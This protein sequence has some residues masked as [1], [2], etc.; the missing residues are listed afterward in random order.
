MKLMNLKEHPELKERFDGIL[1]EERGIAGMLQLIT[2][3]QANCLEQR[4]TLWEDIFKAAGVEMDEW[5]ATFRIKEATVTFWK[6]TRRKGEVK[7]T[8][9]RHDK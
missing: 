9:P 7:S 3:M 1:K 5:D 2:G 6:K 4:K 8:E